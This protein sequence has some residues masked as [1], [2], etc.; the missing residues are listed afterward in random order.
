MSDHRPFPLPGA[1]AQYGPDK[2]VDVLH[3]D[4]H[5]RPDLAAKR[6]D[7]VT[8]TTVRAIEDGVARLVLDAVDLD[9]RAV[10]RADGTALPFRSTSER[11]EIAVE[12]PLARGDELVFAVEYAVEN[13]RRGLYF[14]EREPKHVW[15]QS[16]DSDARFWFPCFDYP[17]EKQTTSATV[18]VPKGQ[19]ALANGAL[20]E[21]RDE[22]D[23]TV[24]RYE[25]RV[26]HATYLVTMVAGTF[27]E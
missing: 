3:I 26:P 2:L 5:L 12:P 6:L 8:T 14:I 18:V 17:A 9:V 1:R 10:R 19:F 16:Q 15:T 27:S 22:G 11:L 21:R 25:Q 24:F 23:T 13:P 20:V 7:G 4:L